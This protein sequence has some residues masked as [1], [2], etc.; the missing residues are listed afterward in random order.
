MKRSTQTRLAELPPFSILDLYR[1][2]TH[3][4]NHGRD[5]SAPMVPEVPTP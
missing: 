2:P 1:R 3:E 4:D 5:Q